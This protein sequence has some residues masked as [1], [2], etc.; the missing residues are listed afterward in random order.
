VAECHGIH[1]DGPGL[2]PRQFDEA[3]I[4]K[5]KSN[6]GKNM[7]ALKT[8]EPIINRLGVCVASAMLCLATASS[9]QAGVLLKLYYDPLT[10]NAVSDLTSAPI[11]PNSPTFYEVL[12]GGL[13]VGVNW[14][15]NYGSWTRG[16]IEAPQTG[17]YTFWIASDDDGEFWLSTNDG[18]PILLKVA[19]N[20]GWVGQHSYE[21]KPA[22]KSALISLVQGQKYYFEMLHKE[23]VGGDHCSVAWTLPDGTFDA[24]IPEKHLWPYP[25]NLADPSYPPVT[26]APVVLTDYL[27]NPVVTLPALISVEEGRPVEMSVTIEATQPAYVQWFSNGVAIAG[28]NLSTYEI[29]AVALGQNGDV[30]SVTVTNTLGQANGST[31]LSVNQDFTAPTLVDALNLGNPG[32]IVAVVFSEAVD[33]V[34]GTNAS[35]YTLDNGAAVTS[36]RPGS[37][38][39]TVLLTTTGV[40]I[41]PSFTVT[42]NNVTD[43]AAT[44]TA[45]SHLVA[46]G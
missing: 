32:G 21:V 4:A 35:N 15:E 40:T 30:Y 41:G 14:G 8:F 13:Q 38:P 37:S 9:S 26:T 7:K 20:V 11:F 44:P 17:Q 3:G 46:A 29:P 18:P 43:L 12:L 23:G 16:Y 6:L 31:T 28:A 24:P 39:D 25:V 19:E 34:T 10:N 33:P 2:E 5:R 1:G 22:Q 27:G 42:V 45:S 36:A